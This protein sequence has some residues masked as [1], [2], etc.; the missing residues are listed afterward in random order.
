MDLDTLEVRGGR[1]NYGSGYPG[2]EGGITMD[3]DTLEVKEWG[4]TM[5]PVP[6]EVMGIAVGLDVLEP[7][8]G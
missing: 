7:G 6:L 2:G 1:D 3:L 5:D 8:G 4:I